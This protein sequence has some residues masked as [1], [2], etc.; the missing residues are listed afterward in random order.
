VPATRGAGDCRHFDLKK[1][2]LPDQGSDGE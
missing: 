2:E 1:P